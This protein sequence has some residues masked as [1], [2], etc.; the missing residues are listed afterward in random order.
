MKA[1]DDKSNKDGTAGH[2]HL[3]VNKDVTAEGTPIPSGDPA[4]IHTAA[5]SVEIPANLLKTGE[6]VIWVVLGYADHAPFAP[7]VIDKVV[8]TI[9]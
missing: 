6:N 7:P 3:F 2:L 5:A 1:A 9:S 8:V 4:I